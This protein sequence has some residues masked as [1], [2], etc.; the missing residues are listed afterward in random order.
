VATQGG[1]NSIQIPS[2][3]HA[4][5][6]PSSSSSG[7]TSFAH[8]V[9]TSGQLHQSSHSQY[10]SQAA[11]TYPVQL[12]NNSSSQYLER[13]HPPHP[14]NHSLPISV[15]SAPV[16][17]EDAIPT[18]MAYPSYT[19]PQ[20]Q[21]TPADTAPCSSSYAL[22]PT[23]QSQLHEPSAHMSSLEYTGVAN[24]TMAAASRRQSSPMN[25]AY[26]APQPSTGSGFAF[27]PPSNQENVDTRVDEV[28]NNIIPSANPT[29][30]P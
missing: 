17:T 25:S 23:L 20:T 5:Q 1:L 8:N 24:C 18:F 21:T 10:Y 19:A 30:R 3:Q 6:G 13:E 28:S 22:G 12:A 7:A 27:L 11:F 2:Q 4:S 26:V 29:P 9:S 15:S 16:F 14:S